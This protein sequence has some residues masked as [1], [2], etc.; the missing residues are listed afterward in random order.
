MKITGSAAGDF[1]VTQPSVNTIQP[2]GSVT[3]SISFSPQGVGSRTATVTVSSNALGMASDVFAIAGTGLEI[4]P[5]VNAAP[6]PG[7][8]VKV[9]P[10]EYAGTN[11]YYSLYLPTDW[12]PGKLYPVI[13]EYALNNWP[14]ANVDG[15]VDD[16][17]LGY[18]ESGGKGFIWIT[19]PFI[20]YTTTPAS[21]A[22]EWWGNGNLSDPQ[23]MQLT[24]QFCETNLI[25]VLQNYGGDPSKVFLTG[26]CAGPWPRA[27]SDC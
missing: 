16:T 24:A 18:Y 15:S 9:V 19:M 14:Q 8:R 20:N 10:P 1:T 6:A 2:G 13:V 25:R 27:S 4:P 3:F 12:T 17:E 22:T 23:G 7:L 11:V 26:F 5:V 21:N